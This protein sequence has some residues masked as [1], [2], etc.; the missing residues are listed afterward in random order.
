MAIPTSE[1]QSINPSAVI[2]LFELQ[3]IASIHGS[4]QLFRWHSGSNQ[5]GNGEIVW[6]GNTYA[7][8]PVEAEGFE[9]TGRG[10]IPRPTLLVSNILSTL[11]TL[12]ASVNAFTPANDLNGSKLTRIRTLASNL[13]AVNF[14]PVTTTSTTTTTIADPADAETVNYT[15]TVANVGGINIFLLNGVNNPVITMKRG[16]TYIFNQ[17]DSSNQ[18]HPLRFKSDSGGSYTTG[19]SASGYSPGYSGATVTFQPPYP[20]APSDLR[21]YCTIHG[22]A[23]G[24][25]I[26]MNNPNTT[27]Q[28]TTTTSGSQTN[29]LG[30]PDPTAEFPL[31]QYV[32]DRKSSENREVV[33]FE[34]A[35]VFDL[36]GVR[37]P[38]RQATRKIFPSIGTFN[39]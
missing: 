23:M 28:T 10:Q 36:V 11:T 4:N 39:Q 12:M 7:R 9:F 16:S 2:E 26:T 29:P 38:K 18:G 3:L 25:T 22:N 31:E 8:F 20:N 27:T 15:V 1:L 13:D 5:N 33:T 19:V 37:A 6:Q 34:L 17:E 24:N 32:I 14:A 35:A 30:T 21:Y